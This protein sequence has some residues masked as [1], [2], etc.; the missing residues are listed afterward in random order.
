MII[1][2]IPEIRR[3]ISA[4]VRTY[5]IYVWRSSGD[6]DEAVNELIGWVQNQ[7]QAERIRFSELNTE[8]YQRLSF[9][10]RHDGAVAI[11]QRP[12]C[13][14]DKLPLSFNQKLD[15]R[16]LALVILQGAEKPG[17]IGA[18]MRSADGAG[19]DA[20]W[21]AD[22]ICD[23]YHHTCIRASLGSVFRF[24]VVCAS[25][26]EILAWLRK[27]KV[28]TYTTCVNARRDYDQIDGRGSVAIVLG[29]EN[30]GL[31]EQW[32]VDDVTPIRIPMQGL[33]DSLN[34]SAS[35]AIV[36]YEVARQRRIG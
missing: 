18:V 3:A 10:D 13:G 1:F 33:A 25:T 2:G 34:L 30:S 9:G 20:V 8:L 15:R 27:H 35:A 16:Q 4:G 7:T 31:D 11:A 32:N 17:N 23:P 19:F 26:Q 36:C 5:E 29:N 14:L 6:N 28:S 12:N 24:P 21:L 22:P